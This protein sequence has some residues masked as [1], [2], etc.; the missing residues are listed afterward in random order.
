MRLLT[1]TR[2]QRL[3]AIK[4]IATSDRVKGYAL[5][6][7]YYEGQHFMKQRYS[8]DYGK[9][10]KSYVQTRSGQSLYDADT[11]DDKVLVKSNWCEPIIE[12][13]GDY[14]RGIAEPIVIS[15]EDGGEHEDE[16][17]T[18]WEENHIDTLTHEAAYDCGIFGNTVLRLKQLA[19]K[20]IKITQLDPASVYEC[21]NPI[22]GE[23][24]STIYWF[25]M[26]K[27]EAST[28][29]PGL[30]FFGSTDE[31]VY[32]CEEWSDDAVY[33]YLDGEVVNERNDE[34][35]VKYLNPYGFQ[36]FFK[37]KGN[38]KESSDIKNVIS[39]NDELNITMTYINEIFRYAAFPMLAPKGT[40]GPDTPVLTEDQLEEVEISPQVILPIPMEK[41]KGEGVEQ[42]VLDH[43]KD[44]RADIAT[45]SGVPLKVLTGE[46]AGDASGVAIER[47][48]GAVIKQAEV[49]R[50][51]MIETYKEL[52]KRI[53]QLLSG[54]TDMPDV[55]VS[56][57]FPPMI[58]L[59][60]NELLDAAIKKQTIGVSQ[61]TI[62]D[63]LGYDYEEE[64]KKRKTELEQED[65]TKID[66][67][68]RTDNQGKPDQGAAPQKGAGQA[69]D[70][71]ARGAQR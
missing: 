28:L 69:D 68:L 38:I 37:I 16:L 48:M 22:T 4:S 44:V 49:R 6:N 41:V 11:E 64:Q 29:Y 40:F 50:N 7:D 31:Y 60:V 52:S 23:R 62:L 54:G 56:V 45:V 33:K 13:I 32:Y 27:S 66:D 21:W 39:L 42:S 43:L 46:I 26:L 12:T 65:L 20:S 25:L 30:Q 47:L 17:R 58:K 35:Q 63:E 70:Q 19:D 36:P 9:K 1:L 8:H 57:V 3:D 5:Y 51:Y 71:R 67:E 14:T 15:L 61:E 10:T 55:K 34:Q 2:E 59:D 18:T 53:L 24:E